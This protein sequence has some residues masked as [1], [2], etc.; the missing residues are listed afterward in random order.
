METVAPITVILALAF[1]SESLTEYFLSD[2]MAATGW[3]RPLLKYAA[4]VVGVGLAFAYGVD[5]LESFLAISPH[6]PYLGQ[7][8]T[9]LLLGRGANYIHDFYSGYVAKK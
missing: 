7:F 1:L 2:L 9:G 8:L 3:G 6:L 5:A 4:A